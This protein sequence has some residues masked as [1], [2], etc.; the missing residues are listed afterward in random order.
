[1]KNIKRKQCAYCGQVPD[2]VNRLYVKGKATRV[3]ICSTCMSK[4]S[5]QEVKDETAK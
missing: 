3:F 5:K 2:T 1:M 4:I